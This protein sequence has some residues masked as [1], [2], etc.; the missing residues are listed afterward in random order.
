MDID[1]LFGLKTVSPLRASGR[2]NFWR[3]CS[4]ENHPALTFVFL[5]RDREIC[6]DACLLNWSLAISIRIL[7]F[8]VSKGKTALNFVKS[9]AAKEFEKNIILNS[10]WT[11]GT[12][13]SRFFA[14]STLLEKL[15]Q[16]FTGTSTLK[17]SLSNLLTN[18]SFATL[19]TRLYQP[20]NGS[21][22]GCSWNNFARCSFFDLVLPWC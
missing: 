9:G 11:N 17:E 15:D 5:V 16:V 6:K 19:R 3:S 7:V 12:I 18:F 21:F 14:T 8:C 20:T 2:G 22:C 1:I 10:T 4:S 13:V